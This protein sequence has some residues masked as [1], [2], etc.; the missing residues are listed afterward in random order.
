MSEAAQG[1]QTMQAIVA[2]VEAGDM[3]RAFEMAESALK[4]GLRHP[5][6]YRLCGVRADSEG[7]LR[8][9]AEAFSAALAMEPDNATTMSALGLAL[10]RIGH[11]EDARALLQR[12]IA[13]EPDEAATHFNLGWT[14]ENLGEL[15]AAAQS[16]ARAIALDPKRALAHAN[17]AAVAAR[18]ARWGEARTHAAAALAIEAGEPTAVMALAMADLGER[19]PEAAQQ[20]LQTLLAQPQRLPPQA[21]ATA[22]S[23]LG[24]SLDAQQQPAA[25]FA[26]WREANAGLRQL[27][28]F[29]FKPGALEPGRALVARIREAFLANPAR[30]WLRRPEAVD[31]AAHA[32][33]PA[34]GFLFGFPRSGTTLTGQVLASHPQIAVLDEQETLADA[35]RRYMTTREGL[36]QLATLPAD[37]IAAQRAAHWQRVEAPA[38]AQRADARVVIDKL[39]INVLNLP[40]IARLFPDARLLL[41]RRDPRDVVLSCF[42]RQFVINPTTWEF[43]DLQSAAHFYAEVMQLTELYLQQLPV[44]VQILRYEDLVADFDAVSARCCAHFGLDWHPDLRDFAEQSK[45]RAVRTVSTAQVARGLYREGVGQWRAYAAE[46]APVMDILAPWVERFGYSA[47]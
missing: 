1:M 24:D 36:D 38:R 13:A 16:Y 47:D 25:A 12:A 28:A 7:R 5:L 39:P 32:G 21:R 15:D 22:Q 45:T 29:R 8:D 4:S 17:A 44:E 10:A 33:R 30:D 27:N 18:R 43:L 40:L 19:Q 2:Q 26:A 41:V 14:H 9:A 35:S 31:V 23:L 34:L 11:L 6:L 3:R 20:R 46:L 37:A 42:R